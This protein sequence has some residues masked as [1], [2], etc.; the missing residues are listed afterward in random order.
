MRNI[1]SS[2]ND[3]KLLI[4]GVQTKWSLSLGRLKS[5][6]PSSSLIL[7]T[8]TMRTKAVVSVWPSSYASAS[9]PRSPKVPF[10]PYLGKV[11]L[12]IFSQSPLS[13]FIIS[14]IV[15]IL[16]ECV[17]PERFKQG[18][19]QIVSFPLQTKWWLR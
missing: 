7:S 13:R 2:E 8:S 3:K 12:I 16:L 1:A 11:Q 14:K 10:Y 17:L 4:L 19:M 18:H 5:V 15:M 6:L 9:V